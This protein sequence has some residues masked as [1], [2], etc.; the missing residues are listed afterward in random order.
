M[1]G[2][3]HGARRLRSHLGRR[4]GLVCCA[5]VIAIAA[6]A[7][8]WNVSGDKG[9]L[10]L[11]GS[12]RTIPVVVE[13]PLAEPQWGFLD[14]SLLRLTAQGTVGDWLKLEAHAVETVSYASGGPTAGYTAQ[15][16]VAQRYRAFDLQWSQA[17]GEH[18]SAALELDRLSARF[19]LPHVDITLGRQAINFSKAL[20]WNPL[21][22]FLPF[23]P[24]AFDR[25]YKPG[26]DAARV[27]LSLGESS[28][29]ELVGA[30]GRTLLVDAQKGSSA[31]ESGFFASSWT[32][33]ALIARAFT[34]LAHVD[35][36]LQG[37]KIFGGAEVGLGAAGEL[38][39][40][41]LHGE[42]SFVRADQQ[43][44]TLFPDGR[45]SVHEVT[46]QEDSLSL[47]VGADH[48]FD[49]DLTLALEVF[50]NGAAASHDLILSAARV[51]LGDTQS[52]SRDLGAATASYPLTPLWTAS[53]ATLV[54]FSDGS[55][56]I[57]PSIAWSAANE[58]DVLAGA[59]IGIGPRPRTD[60]TF[61]F[62]APQSEFGSYP[63]IVYV[64]AK[65]YF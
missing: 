40:W 51:A 26:V 47:V 60:P 49:N 22:L 56:L 11:G 34:T 3:V 8:A 36:S 1:S 35:L 53:L 39:S 63:N 17:S 12:L 13:Q 30:L 42:L 55:S 4:V 48:R 43:P 38:F 14:Q 61:H 9:S 10:D 65:L 33:S 44:Q 41:G 62:P 6:P 27:Q 16:A 50:H 28:G 57:T 46:V 15:T 25:D 21:D 23:D 7:R 45:G 32:G 54:S 29:I 24:R 52:L 19:S 2:P 18:A 64:E 31:Q 37:G 58:V 5:L 59:L 20:F